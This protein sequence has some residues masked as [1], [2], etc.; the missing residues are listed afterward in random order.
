MVETSTVKL[1]TTIVGSDE[2]WSGINNRDLTAGSFF[3]A[4]QA[5]SG[6]KV[7][8][9]GSGGGIHPLG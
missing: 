3:D 8:G 6:A 2:R 1:R 9:N 7:G 5:R 4:G